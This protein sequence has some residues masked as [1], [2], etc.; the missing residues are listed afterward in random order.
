MKKLIAAFAVLMT[1]LLVSC[2]NS[3]GTTAQTSTSK[4]M[5]DSLSGTYVG[6]NGSALTLF[7]DG[8]SEYYYMLY[9]SMD[10]DKGAGNWNYKDGTLTWMYNDKTIIATINEQSALSFTLEQTD[11]W[12]R[13]QFIKA[14]D[15]AQNRSVNEYR[16]LLKDVLARPEMD[17]YDSDL[18]STY[19]FGQFYLKIPFYWFVKEKSEDGITFYAEDGSDE[20]AILMITLIP[21]A[22]GWTK[23]TFNENGIA[24]WNG[25]FNSMTSDGAFGTILQAPIVSE[26]NGLPTVN[27]TFSLT[28]GGHVYNDTA[29]LI[30]DE[31]SGAMLGL[32]LIT[33]ENTIFKYD[34]DYIKIIN[35]V[36]SGNVETSAPSGS[37]HSENSPTT[38][39]SDGVTPELKA[40]LDSYEAFMDQYIAFMQKYKNSDDTYAMLSDYLDMMQQYADFAEKVDQYDTDKMSAVDSAYYLEV[41]TRVAKKLYSAAIQ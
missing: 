19:H 8:T 25:G 37:G 30:L 12:N 40:F 14:S 26:V 23:S 3:N 9:P 33:T 18:N 13:E 32:Q 29:V 15:A 6:K 17:N 20:T 11:G 31:K 21:N 1:L 35:S 2:G 38:T 7:P 34:N 24:A 4:S 16:Q 27:G 41:T 10:V 39:T 28:K 5:V 36:M 22:T